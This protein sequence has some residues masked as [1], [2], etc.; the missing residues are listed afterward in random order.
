MVET[1]AELVALR[2]AERLR[3]ELW[4]REGVKDHHI[5]GALL[6]LGLR[7]AVEEMQEGANAEDHCC[8]YCDRA[9]DALKGVPEPGLDLPSVRLNEH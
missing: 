2:F 5:A 3:E 1:D 8:P 6:D 4:R 9:L 7:V